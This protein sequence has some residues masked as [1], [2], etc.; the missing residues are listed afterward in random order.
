MPGLAIAK[1]GGARRVVMSDYVQEC[2]DAM[3]ASAAMNGL[4][5]QRNTGEEQDVGALVMVERLDWR[6][7][8]A[9]GTV[10]PALLADVVLVCRRRLVFRHAV[11]PRALTAV[12]VEQA[13]DVVFAKELGDWLPA[14]INGCLRPGGEAYL[15]L[16][17]QR[18]GVR[19]YTP[20][21]P[22]ASHAN[23]GRHAIHA[24]C[25]RCLQNML[26]R[27]NFQEFE[28]PGAGG[29]E[30]AGWFREHLSAPARGG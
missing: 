23:R 8:H 3:Q 16:P 17:L 7:V 6:D 9:G 12:R 29:Q 2:L 18:V 20:A 13:S 25:G 27:H 10:P 22:P 1:A 11:L 19:E 14:A 15:L 30:M 24:L 26:R 5:P 21:R 28:P 4:Q